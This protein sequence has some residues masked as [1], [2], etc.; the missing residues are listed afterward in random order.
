[1]KR[2]HPWLGTGTPDA[3]SGHISLA[4]RLMWASV[5]I[6]TLASSLVLAAFS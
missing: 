5:I 4:V 1:M 3:A 6:F 2:D